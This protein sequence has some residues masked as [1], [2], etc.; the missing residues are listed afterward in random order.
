MTPTE[1]HLAIQIRR[2]EFVLGGAVAA[3]P[4][5]TRAQP[6]AMPVIGFV[7]LT[8]LEA[9][10]ENLPTFREG[11]ADVGYIE[12]K[13]VAIE[14]RWAQGRNDRL[15]TLVADKHVIRRFRDGIMACAKSASDG[16]SGPHSKP[17]VIGTSRH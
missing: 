15:P 16:L 11:L 2:R 10:R 13:N 5:S 12:G 14:Y 4:L 7:H 17:V 3:W 9:N 1:G 8:S 6:S